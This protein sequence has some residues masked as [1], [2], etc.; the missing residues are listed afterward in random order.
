MTVATGLLPPIYYGLVHPIVAIDCCHGLLPE[1][2]ATDCCWKSL[3][4]D[5]ARVS[6]A[7]DCHGL[8]VEIVA[9]G[10]CKEVFA[11][12]ECRRDLEHRLSDA[13]WLFL[14]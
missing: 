3:P 7:T 13:P 8:L 10:C 12:E 6:F 14:L 11:K 9:T 5:A 4:K 1:I 2:V